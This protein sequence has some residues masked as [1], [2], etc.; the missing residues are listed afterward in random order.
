MAGFPPGTQRSSGTVAA[1]RRIVRR[2][3][4]R[5]LT[6]RIGGRIWYSNDKFICRRSLTTP[7][8]AFEPP[9]RSHARRFTAATNEFC[10]IYREFTDDTAFMER[11]TGKVWCHVA[12]VDDD[13]AAFLWTS[14][15]DCEFP[16]PLN[17]SVRLGQG[18]AYVMELYTRP[19]YRGKGLALLLYNTL[20]EELRGL[21]FKR[22]FLSVD[23]ANR[24]PLRAMEKAGYDQLYL[25]LI[26]RRAPFERLIATPCLPE[27]EGGLRIERI[28]SGLLPFRRP[29]WAITVMEPGVVGS[30]PG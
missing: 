5:G 24:A 20:S 17:T 30:L 29:R 21:G 15:G 19:A 27:Y 6:G 9:L 1:M 22:A 10:A 23:V 13:P 3:G 7:T 12:F 11:F 26:R 25:L 14:L 2:E 28:G 8:R 4:V 16:S 18:D